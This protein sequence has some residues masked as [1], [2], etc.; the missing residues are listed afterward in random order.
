MDERTEYWKICDVEQRFNTTQSTVR[1]LASTWLL[2]AFG[3][4]AMLLRTDGTV[5][6]L[7]PKPVL[8]VLV[9][10]MASIGLFTLW[11]VDQIVY[12]RLLG[13]AFMVG[14]KM[15]H[16][17]HE[18]PPMRALMMHS[19]EGVGMSRWLRMFY[20]IPMVSFLLITVVMALLPEMPGQNGLE[21][22]IFLIEHPVL[23]VITL[24]MVQVALI[25]AIFVKDQDIH[26]QTKERARLFNDKGFT[27]L[28][29]GKSFQ[30]ENVIR[31]YVPS[32]KRK[33]ADGAH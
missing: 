12:Q 6:W 20:V 25:I 19:A 9:A 16:D 33:P 26:I 10:T 11:I 22:G 13:S 1:A 14:L 23:L 30:A 8:L 4:I 28:F 31:Q 32:S 3:A 18:L 17:N 15:E 5:T 27:K 2:T 29:L 21:D 7:F 24:A